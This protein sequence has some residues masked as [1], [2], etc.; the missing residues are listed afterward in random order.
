MNHSLVSESFVVC[1]WMRA[2]SAVCVVPREAL[3]VISDLSEF[4][5][6]S[7]GACVVLLLSTFTGVLVQAAVT[8]ESSI[9]FI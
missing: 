4:V 7:T 1:M 9:F 5:S 2:T 3:G 8:S 6:G